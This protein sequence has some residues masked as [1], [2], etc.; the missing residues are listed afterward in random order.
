MLV[1]HEPHPNPLLKGEGNRH[2][3]K[4]KPKIL[5]LKTDGI[6]CDEELSFAFSLAGGQPEY[7]HINE[8]RKKPS[9]LLDYQILAL[10]GGFSY[11]DD[12][13]S[14]KILAAEMTS[15]FSDTIQ[16]FIQRKDTLTIGIC[17]GFQV[18]VRTGL[19]PFAKVGSMDVTLANNNSGHLECR[20]I[21]LEI[22][23]NNTS[24]F[25]SNLG[26]K[27]VS[28]QVAHGEGRFFTDEK[29]LKKV[30]DENLV[31]LR[32]VD[33]KGKVTQSYPANPNGSLNS[34]A[35]ITDPTGRI[36][37]LMPHPERFVLKEQHP[38]WRRLNG[39]G[40]HGLP[41]FQNAVKY[42]KQA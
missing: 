21:K 31:S 12:I 33:D 41:I 15:F 35:G 36:F 9:R 16:K 24:P 23:T 40:P 37:G 25:L 17:N 27:Q 7:L 10:A 28:Y 20:W 3:M 29:T 38:N 13:A 6:N 32:Y 22:E 18:L 2:I 14:G 39:E 5:I 8:L 34:I 11:G 19:L 30:E 26:G 42:V 4:S 1:L